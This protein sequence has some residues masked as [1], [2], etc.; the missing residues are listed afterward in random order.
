MIDSSPAV[1][2]R[3]S[4]AITAQIVIIGLLMTAS[5][6]LA[7]EPPGEAAIPAGALPVDARPSG[8]GRATV[9]LAAES[10]VWE[11]AFDR[12]AEHRFE[13]PAAP[14]AR[15]WRARHELPA[16]FYGP[17]CYLPD[18]TPVVVHQSIGSGDG[19]R[20]RLLALSG[21]GFRL[22]SVR[23][24]DRPILKL[25]AARD[26]GL[27][28]AY[29]P[30]PG[31]RGASLERLDGDQVRRR[32]A[33]P[34]GQMSVADWLEGPSGSLWLATG[35]G[36]IEIPS[37]DSAEP[38]RRSTPRA[39]RLAIDDAAL[40]VAGSGLS[41]FDGRR[42]AP[43]ALRWDSAPE[44]PPI[45][46]GVLDLAVTSERRW[47]AL[48][49]G[50]RLAI[51]EPDSGNVV[52][53]GPA[54]G[55]PEG[56]SR[57]LYEPV[58]DTLIFG[59]RDMR[60]FVRLWRGVARSLIGDPQPVLD[61]EILNRTIEERPIIG[62]QNGVQIQRC[63]GDCQIEVSLDRAASSELRLQLTEAPRCT[64]SEGLEA[65]AACQ[66]EESLEILLLALGV[67]GAE[68]QLCQDRSA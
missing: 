8:D 57:L 9:L 66:Q 55:V 7:V 14:V 68:L 38:I 12:R 36:L 6:A 30:V 17:A 35:L 1:R 46:G 63:R 34:S 22:W 62:H 39:A 64:E 49:S 3:G 40:A 61:L 28:V 25:L 59:G 18:G 32:V 20:Y 5:T 21:D 26:G 43:I 23:L 54:D 11:L 27:W 58:T 47:L 29:Q 16:G 51:V 65:H 31:A 45:L 4:C 19:R 44:A 10:G 41:R 48:Y 67:P 50:S 33:L 52:L 13:S 24:A 15:R 2:R 42:L 37:I 56:A 60:P 53:L